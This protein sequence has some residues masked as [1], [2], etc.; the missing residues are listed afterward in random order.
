MSAD[1][2]LG[3]CIYTMFNSQS[4]NNDCQ[5]LPSTFHLPGFILR[6]CIY[7]SLFNALIALSC[8]R[9]GIHT[10][11]AGHWSIGL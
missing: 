2:V 8:G 7:V 5:H 6:T 3:T 11:A 10:Q 4:T 9:A 1:Y